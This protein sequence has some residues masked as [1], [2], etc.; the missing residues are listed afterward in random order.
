MKQ[1]TRL[2]PTSER[3][4]KQ[5]YDDLKNRE[6]KLS[7]TLE[8]IRGR[9]GAPFYGQARICQAIESSLKSREVKQW[10]VSLGKK[11]FKIREC[12]EKVVKFI[13][14]SKDFVAA[15]VTS[16]PHAALA[17]AGVCLLLPVRRTISSRAITFNH[18][19]SG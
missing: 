1:D 3:L 11:A 12:G 18:D 10:V 19:Q 9:D 6:P 16:E 4:W 14:W 15:A 2:T 13:I 8:N 5:A 17:W 7:E